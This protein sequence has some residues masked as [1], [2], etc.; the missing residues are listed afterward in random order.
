MT[1]LVVLGRVA[2]VLGFGLVFSILALLLER[3]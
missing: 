1:A 3:L 2:G